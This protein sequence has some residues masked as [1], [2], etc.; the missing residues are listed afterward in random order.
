MDVSRQPIGDFVRRARQAR[1]L[2]CEVVGRRS[3]TRFDRYIKVV[4]QVAKLEFPAPFPFQDE[5]AQ[6]ALFYEGAAQLMELVEAEVTIRQM[7]AD[8]A[9]EKVGLILKGTELP[10]I[11]DGFDAAR[12]TLFELTCASAL[13]KGGFQVTVPER[14]SDVVAHHPAGPRFQVE[15]K[16]PT[17]VGTLGRNVRE[18]ATRVNE[19]C[20]DSGEHGDLGMLLI[21]I[22]RVAK[23][24]GGTPQNLTSSE[25]LGE[26]N[27]TF[28]DAI[29]SVRAA[30]KAEGLVLFPQI[31]VAGVVLVGAVF[32]IREGILFPFSQT[33]LFWTGSESDPRTDAVKQALGQTIEFGRD[34]PASFG[35]VR[36][37]PKMG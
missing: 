37:L 18:A 12:N 4:E 19:R 27:Q 15:C 26:M 16:R 22:D 8:L 24:I 32:L 5:P 9:R 31:P 17:H 30:A 11:D 10:P 7:G 34:L 29:E 25:F 3:F 13:R 35:A 6:Q 21:G 2:T 28:K 1:D 14:G 33:G 23:L 20:K 36:V